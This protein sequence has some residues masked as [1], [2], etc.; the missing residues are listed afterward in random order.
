[1]VRGDLATLRIA[2]AIAELSVD[3]NAMRCWVP[4]FGRRP[5]VMPPET[6][7]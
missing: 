7:C 3:T 4:G 5:A 1:M 6:C 2:Q